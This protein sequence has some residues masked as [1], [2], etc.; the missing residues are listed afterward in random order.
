MPLTTNSNPSDI[1][2]AYDAYVDRC[3]DDYYGGEYG[4][5]PQCGDESLNSTGGRN[6]HGW[7]V[8]SE[9]VNDEC[10]YSFDDCDTYD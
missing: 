6:R 2:R 9:C 1:A 10:G 3:H 8:Q 7:W 5:C 4:V